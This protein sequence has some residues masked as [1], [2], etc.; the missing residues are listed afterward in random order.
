VTPLPLRGR[1]I[2]YAQLDDRSDLELVV[3]G[4][5]TVAIIGGSDHAIR[6]SYSVPDTAILVRAGDLDGDGVPD[7]VVGDGLTVTRILASPQVSR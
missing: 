3:L 4:T 6:T 5:G 2:C 7:L 1:S